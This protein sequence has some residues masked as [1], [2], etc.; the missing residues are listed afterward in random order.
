M[1]KKTVKAEM[2]DSKKVNVEIAPFN[3]ARLNAYL[4]SR[5]EHPDRSRPLITVTDVLNEAM[6]EFFVEAA[7]RIQAAQP[8]VAEASKSDSKGGKH[9]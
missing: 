8:K 4:R 2:G 6:D 9:K 1:P 7:K 5:N 3:S